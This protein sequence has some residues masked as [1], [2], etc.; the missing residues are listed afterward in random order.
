MAS[1]G[2][3]TGPINLGNPEETSVRALAERII[4]ATGSSSRL[5]FAALPVDGPRRRCP[6]IK[7]AKALLGWQPSVSLDQGL[8]RTICYFRTVGVDS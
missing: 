6:D 4:T 7:R 5:E 8:A 1:D 2:A 3:V